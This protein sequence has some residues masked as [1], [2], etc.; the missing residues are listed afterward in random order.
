[1]VVLLIEMEENRAPR[2]LLRRQQPGVAPDA[3]QVRG[4]DLLDRV[5]V[6][7]EEAGESCRVGGHDAERDLLPSRLRSP[8]V[9]V[10]RELDAVA[11]REAHEPERTGADHRSA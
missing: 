6:S 2:D 3:R 4:G 5:E 8:I 10:A 11:A 9:V 1:M 7:G